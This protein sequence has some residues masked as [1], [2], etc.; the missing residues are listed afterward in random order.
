[1]RNTFLS[2]GYTPYIVIV[3]R[4]K[5]SY[6]DSL[7]CELKNTGMNQTYENFIL[8]AKRDNVVL[9]NKNCLEFEDYCH[10]QFFQLDTELISLGFSRIFGRQNVIDLTYNKNDIIPHFIRSLNW[11]F[12]DISNMLTNARRVHV[13][14]KKSCLV[15][16][17]KNS[18]K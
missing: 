7:F 11:F 1:M 6:I 3:H 8:N 10:N 12:G 2:L 5:D 18:N 13:T 14:I 15:D 4:E 16:Y 17:Y 9:F